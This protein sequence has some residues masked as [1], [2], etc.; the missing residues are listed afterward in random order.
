MLSFPPPVSGG[1]RWLH[2]QVN[3]A[4][5]VEALHQA[6]L[7]VYPQAV[8]TGLA[9]GFLARTISARGIHLVLD[10]AH[11]PAASWHLVQTWKE[12]HRGTTPTVIF[13]GLKDKNLSQMIEALSQVAARFFWF[14]FRNDRTA[15]PSDLQTPDHLPR[16]VYPD[17]KSAIAEARTLRDPILVTGSLYL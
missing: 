2:Q 6:N 13:G 14:R 7:P 12:Y 3:A 1:S 15:L 5:A 8:A 11:N 4:V 17:V 9:T 10:G 16:T